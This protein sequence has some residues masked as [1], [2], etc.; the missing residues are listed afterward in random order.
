MPL[1]FHPTV[2]N[3]YATVP[4]ATVLANG[5]T[6]VGTI[7]EDVAAGPRNGSATAKGADSQEARTAEGRGQPKAR[8]R[9]WVW[10][11]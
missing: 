11:L 7:D 4:Y 8:G 5:G 3:P 1:H 10:A 2:S 9:D 6:K